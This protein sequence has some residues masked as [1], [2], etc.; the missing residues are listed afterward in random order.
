M[1]YVYCPSC[2]EVSVLASVEPERCAHCRKAAF[3]VPIRRSWQYWASAGVILAGAAAVFLTNY[4][5]LVQRIL[6]FV[7]FFAV[8]LFFSTWGLQTSKRL[9][10]ELGRSKGAEKG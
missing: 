7:P 8:G 3:P 5:D 1:K 6:L 2:D 4:A 9:A 10:L